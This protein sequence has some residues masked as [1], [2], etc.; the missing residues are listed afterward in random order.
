MLSLKKIFLP[1]LFLWAFQATSAQ[2]QVFEIIHPDVD[3]GKFKL[4]VLSG[5]TLSEVEDGEEAAA[6][7]FALGYGV[8]DF[9]KPTFAIELADIE[10]GN[11]EVEGIEFT[12]VFLFTTGEEEHGHDDDDEDHGHGHGGAF[13]LFAGLEI[14]NEGGIDEGALEIGPIGEVTIGDINLIGNLI[15]EV[16]FKDEDVG[17]AY[18]FGASTSVS[19]SVTLG[20]E[21]YGEL[22]GFFGGTEEQSHFIGP[23]AYFETSLGK[24]RVL[25]PRVALLFGLSEDAPDAVLS[26]NFEMKF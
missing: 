11:L 15:V 25:E 18:A 22:E 9:W 6:F 7:E 14:P 26:F 16:P 19:E 17:L 12:N 8:T 3:K 1:G 5:V 20:I 24:D 23:A 4:E 2:A 21:A 13:G 10:G